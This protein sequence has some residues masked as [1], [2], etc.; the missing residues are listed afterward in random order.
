[1]TRSRNIAVALAI[2]AIGG[3]AV[4]FGGLGP[5]VRG[6]SVLSVQT[7][8]SGTQEGIAQADRTRNIMFETLTAPKPDETN[9]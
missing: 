4:A 6:M 1:M 8:A 5:E 7:S 9:N 3:L 2:T